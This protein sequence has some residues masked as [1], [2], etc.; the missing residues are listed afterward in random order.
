MD[1]SI[2]ERDTFFICGYSVETTLEQNDKDVSALYSDFFGSG[3]EAILMMLKGSKKGYYGLIWYT[4]GK[5]RYCYLLGIEVGQENI[6]PEN[7]ILKKISKATYAVTRFTKS[8]D[9]IEAWTNFYYNVIP[10]AGFKVD[11]QYNFYFEYYP[12]NIN[13]EFELWVPVV[14]ADV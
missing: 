11:E 12:I 3:K 6:A 13:G 4:E 1:I 2:V 5:E 7:S 10:K 9:I 14:K 8:E